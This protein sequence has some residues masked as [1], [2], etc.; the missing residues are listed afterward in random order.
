MSQMEMGTTGLTLADSL[1]LQEQNLGTSTQR[2]WSNGEP[3][4]DHDPMFSDE[5]ETAWISND[6]SCK[7]GD[8]H[9]I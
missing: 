3:E 7:V 6:N 8:S 9:R 5:D 1:S 4:F 2:N